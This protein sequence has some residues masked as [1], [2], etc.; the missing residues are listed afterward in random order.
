[1][2]K[3]TLLLALLPAF[4]MLKAQVIEDK[5]EYNRENQACLMMGYNFPP[6]AVENGVIARLK[7]LGY[8]G[9]GERGLFNKDKGFRVYKNSLIADIS[10]SRYDYIINVV[11]RSR[12]ESDEA[13][14]YFIIMKDDQNALSRLN[15]D[16]L[17]KAKAFLIN[18]LPDIEAE[19]L[20]LQILAQEETLNKAEKKLKGL[21]N[22]KEDMEKR[23]SKLQENI[24]DNVKEQERQ[25]SEIENQRKALEAL[26]G[27]RKKST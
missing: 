2:K 5:I 12:K 15:T 1:M 26:I 9:K 14:L 11:R 3:I 20:E 27:K 16:E 21:Q 4:F 10:V 24:S 19:N 17:G 8:T 22:D 6:E 23:L 13:E 7:K 25:T 18:L